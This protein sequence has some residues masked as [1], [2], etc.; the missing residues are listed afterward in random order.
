MTQESVLKKAIKARLEEQGA[1][2][3]E[4]KGGAHSKPGDPDIVACVN[5]RFLAIEAKTPDGRLSESQAL[6]ARQILASEGLWVCARSVGDVEEALRTLR[7][8]P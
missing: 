4:I 5:G 3:C 6:R 8:S 7:N 1:Y 2:W